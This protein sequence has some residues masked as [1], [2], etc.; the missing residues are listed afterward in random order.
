MYIQVQ[1]HMQEVTEDAY[2]LHHELLQSVC[3]MT[4]R[5]EVKTPITHIHAHLH[6]HNGAP[7]LAVALHTLH[8]TFLLKSLHSVESE[9]RLSS[10]RKCPVY[11]RGWRA[12]CSLYT[13]MDKDRTETHSPAVQTPFSQPK[14]KAFGRIG[15]VTQDIAPPPPSL[16]HHQVCPF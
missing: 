12:S 13:F 6:F 14:P 9:P 8:H 11:I 7:H 1:S 3:M 4:P 16:L 5:E 15:E 10:A 2:K